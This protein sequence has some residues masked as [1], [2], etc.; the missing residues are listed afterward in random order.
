MS[1]VLT[2]WSECDKIVI[3]TRAYF[4]RLI[5]DKKAAS[6]HFL[7]TGHAFL[8]SSSLIVTEA[9]LQVDGTYMFRLVYRTHPPK[10]VTVPTRAGPQPNNDGQF[11]RPDRGM[12]RQ[13]REKQVRT[14]CMPHIICRFACASRHP[15]DQVLVD[16]TMDF[17]GSCQQCLI[18]FSQFQK[19]SSTFE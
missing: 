12:N 16:L 10:T 2:R 13:S 18:E 6:V 3:F 4:C 5:G 7:V 14:A 8:F 15:V 17:Q 19:C 11:Y 1:N 9:Y